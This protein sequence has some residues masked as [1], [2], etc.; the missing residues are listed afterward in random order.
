MISMQHIARRRA[1]AVQSPEVLKAREE[2][3]HRFVRYRRVRLAPPIALQP[4]SSASAC[5]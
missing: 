2:A 1:L 3:L 4:L 5:G